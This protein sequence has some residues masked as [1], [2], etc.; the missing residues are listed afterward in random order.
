MFEL[1]SFSFPLGLLVDSMD[2]IMFFTVIVDDVVSNSNLLFLLEDD[3]V[4][5]DDEEDYDEDAPRVL[6]RQDGGA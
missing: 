2:K 4:P 3:D 6:K 1:S 5:L